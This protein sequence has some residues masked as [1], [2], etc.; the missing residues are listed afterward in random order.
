MGRLITRTKLTSASFPLVSEYLGETVISYNSDEREAEYNTPQTYYGHNI[1]PTAH[2]YGSIGY[3][4]MASVVSSTEADFLD[5]FTLRNS[6]EVKVYFAHTGDGR[7]FVLLAGNTTWL[8][9]N[10]IAATA[11]TKVTVAHINGVS[12][13]YFANVGCYYYNFTTQLLVAQTLTG[14]TAAN[15]KGIVATS[16]YLLAWTATSIAWSSLVDPTDFTPSLITGA[17]GGTV[18]DIKGSITACAALT[19]G[20]IIYTTANAVAAASTGNTQYPF[21]FKE[22]VS[23]GGLASLDLVSFAANAGNQFAYT[24]SGLQA[25]SLQQAQTIFPEVTDFISGAYFEDFD[26][27]TLTFTATNLTSTL[28]KKLTVI[29]DRYLI[30]SYGMYSLTH[31]LVYDLAEK[32][33][34]KLKLSHVHCFE[35]TLLDP[36]VQETPKRSLAFLQ[37]SGA[38]QLVDFSFGSTTA[39]GVLILGKYQYVRSRMLQLEEVRFE[40]IKVGSTFN[41]YDLYS[42]K[43]KTLDGSVAGVLKDSSGL[44]RSYSFHQVAMNHSLVMVGA[45]YAVS[46]SLAFNAHGSR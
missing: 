27:T 16:G 10:T 12:Y 7:N 19:A 20:F 39:K 8:Q 38:I 24:T 32:R 18:Q 30:I 31:A 15:V 13:I 4:S 21:S 36:E 44:Y 40:N 3:L 1:M 9:I 41:L 26:E 22:L 46:L 11:N 5:I 34:G 6:S 42:L 45:F 37:P 35:Y 23:S 2:G 33:W 28:K 14:L 17:G 25:L 43:G 29:A